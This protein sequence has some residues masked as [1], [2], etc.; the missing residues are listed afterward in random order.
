M[1]IEVLRLPEDLKLIL[2]HLRSR[3]TER[4]CHPIRV[5]QSAR[6]DCTDFSF[7]IVFDPADL[8]RAIVN[9]QIRSAGIAVK[10]LAAAPQC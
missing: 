6:G 10:G 8:R 7:D 4:P 5:R 2:G 1:S 9:K 3:G